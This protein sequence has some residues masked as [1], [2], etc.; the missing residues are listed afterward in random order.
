MKAEERFLDVA[1]K[2]IDNVK[3]VIGFSINREREPKRKNK[4]IETLVS[5][6]THVKKKKNEGGNIFTSEEQLSL[7]VSSF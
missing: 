2:N 7:Y 3:Q 5:F 1:F 4:L 6:K